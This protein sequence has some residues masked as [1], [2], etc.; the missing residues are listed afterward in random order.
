MFQ[1]SAEISRRHEARKRFHEFSCSI[2]PIGVRQIVFERCGLPASMGY[3]VS[4]EN[5]HFISP[6]NRHTMVI[7]ET[8]VK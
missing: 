1:R 4:V 7:I 8:P 2:D 5:G 3:E 6:D